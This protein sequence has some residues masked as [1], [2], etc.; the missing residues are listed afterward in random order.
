MT[1]SCSS[2]CYPPAQHY[3]WYKKANHN[4]KDVKV[5]ENQN[6]TVYSDELGIYYCSARN[7]ISEGLSD[8]MP[9]FLSGE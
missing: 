7:E 5:S 1:L 3:S 4:G 9:L 6:H 8:P 2:V